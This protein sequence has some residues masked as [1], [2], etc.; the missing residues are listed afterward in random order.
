MRGA[1]V[2]Q[3]HRCDAGDHYDLMFDTGDGL[4]TF[5][6]PAPLED[7][8]PSGAV[9]RRLPDHRSVYL[10]YEGPVRGGRGTVTI[11]ERGR[12]DALAAGA[13][14]WDARL[15]GERFNGRVQLK[16]IEAD[17]FAFRRI[18]DLSEPA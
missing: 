15:R 2:L 13:D 16:H 17:R 4:A 8:P 12:Y 6:L 1:F 18:T 14:C 3:F 10:T 11:A 5:Q 9:V 7:M